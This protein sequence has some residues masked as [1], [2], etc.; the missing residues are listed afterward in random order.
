MDRYGS[1]SGIDSHGNQKG[2]Q[3]PINDNYINVNPAENWTSSGKG[4][5][6]TR[7][8]CECWCQSAGFGGLVPYIPDDGYCY[9]GWETETLYPEDPSI[10]D[11]PCSTPDYYFG[12]P[13]SGCTCECE[14][15]PGERIYGCCISGCSLYNILGQDVGYHNLRFQCLN[16]LPESH[17]PGS[18]GG[19]TDCTCGGSNMFNSEV[20][21]AFWLESCAYY[22]GWG[23][24]A[25]CG[26][27]PTGTYFC[28]PG[29]IEQHV[30]I[31]NPPYGQSNPKKRGGG[32]AG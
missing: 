12:T 1:Q 30:C 4:G 6:G 32:Y 21:M 19:A 8:D 11:Y 24:N 5:G 2:N 28:E 15:A 9:H 26:D 22:D 13:S 29:S 27:L 20:G 18:S 25:S 31:A 17:M 7:S 14:I 23:G 16:G 3:T 10:E